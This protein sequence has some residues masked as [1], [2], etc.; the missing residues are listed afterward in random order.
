[1]AK[2]PT[3][4]DIARALSISTGTVH[5]ALHGHSRVSAVTKARVLQL[6]Q[7]LEYRPNLAARYLS[8]GRR[9]SISVNL[10]HGISPFFGE[11]TAGIQEEARSLGG[12]NVDVQLR[13]YPGISEGEEEALRA[14]LDAKVDGIITWSGEPEKIRTLLNRASQNNIPVVCV[15]TDVPKSGRLALVSVDTLASGAMAADVIGLALGGQGK[16]A[17][18]LAEVSTMEHAEKLKSFEDTL[19][20]FYP[21]VQ[22]LAPIED[23]NVE[24][25]A[26]EKCRQ[27]FS[28]HPDLGGIYVST[29]ASM[30]VL[31]ATRDC[32]LAHKMTIVATDLFPALINEFRAGAITASIFQR[33]RSQGRMAFRVLYEFLS[34]DKCPRPRLTLMPHLITRGSLDFMCHRLLPR[35]SSHH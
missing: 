7:E 23:R 19:R 16:A 3:I 28:Q 20:A 10:L 6:A 34:Y 14:A 31:Q 12:E 9:L 13:T 21:G 30:P 1:M 18:T 32:G 33:P 24:A 25:V 22:M 29:D 4:L 8:S 2:R 26:Y 17:I 35:T 11:V 5:R 27:M 15:S